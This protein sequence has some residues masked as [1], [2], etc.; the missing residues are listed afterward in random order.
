MLC[1]AHLPLLREVSQ[2]FGSSRCSGLF[3]PDGDVSSGLVSCS[4]S[5]LTL[6]VGS[7]DTAAAALDKLPGAWSC[8]SVGSTGM[9]CAF[10]KRRRNGWEGGSPLE[11]LLSVSEGDVWVGN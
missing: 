4:G 6:S 10:R 3:P 2:T 8:P 7:A 11:T 5:Q 1:P 9:G